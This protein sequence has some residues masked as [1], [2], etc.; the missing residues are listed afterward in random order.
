MTYLMAVLLQWF[1]ISQ[2]II[3]YVIVNELF[4]KLFCEIVSFLFTYTYRDTEYKGLQLSLDQ[5]ASGK[6]PLYTSNATTI[7]E[8]RK[9]SKTR[10]ARA[11]TK[12]RLSPYPQVGASELRSAPSPLLRPPASPA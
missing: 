10:L 2:I 11:K 1:I 6:A 9:G 3:M 7:A 5:V 8:S 4:F 12:P